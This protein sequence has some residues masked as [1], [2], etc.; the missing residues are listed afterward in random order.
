MKPVFLN[1]RIIF[2]QIDLQKKQLHTGDTR[3]NIRLKVLDGF[4]F[5][6][7]ANHLLKTY[8]LLRASTRMKTSNNLWLYGLN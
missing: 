3:K 8:T 5:G 4:K 6:K 7:S 2:K 1:T